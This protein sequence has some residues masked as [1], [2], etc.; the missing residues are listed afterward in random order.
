MKL[1]KFLMMNFYWR[2]DRF[3]EKVAKKYDRSGRK[4]LD[5]GAGTC[6]YRQLFTKLQY[7]SQDIEQN[8][9]NTIDFVGDWKKIET[10]SYDYILC[11]QVLEHLPDPH[12]AFR[13]FKRILKPSGKLFL[14]TNFIYQIHMEPRDYFRF[15]EYGL[16]RL[17]EA[18][19]F[20]VEKLE[21]QGGIFQTLAYLINTL[22]LRMGLEKSPW[23]YWFYIVMFSPVIVITN[24]IAVGLDTAIKSNSLVINYGVVYA[25]SSKI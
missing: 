20:K 10:S 15:T 17:G 25:A 13:E 4:L 19:G 11:T 22:P 24:L 1:L 2:I 18:N 6:K 3:V 14:T 5:I 12:Q 16:K 8:A 9:T 21:R 23:S 7:S